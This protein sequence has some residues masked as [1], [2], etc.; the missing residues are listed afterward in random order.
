M[1]RIDRIANLSI[2]PS[3]ILMTTLMSNLC[4]IPYNLAGKILQVT[5]LHFIKDKYIIVAW[6]IALAKQTI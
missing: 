5:Y 4:I 2:F 3:V 1:H 6:L